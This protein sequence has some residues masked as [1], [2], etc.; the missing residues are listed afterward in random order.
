[1]L[2]DVLEKEEYVVKKILTYRVRFCTN[3]DAT[4]K[5]YNLLST[6]VTE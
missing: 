4:T 6:C 5:L 3:L 1:M 2:K